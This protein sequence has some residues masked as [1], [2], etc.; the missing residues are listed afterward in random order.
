MS[1]TDEPYPVV[2]PELDAIWTQIQDA[3]RRD[4][5]S[6]LYVRALRGP[7]RKEE[8]EP[9]EDALWRQ[10]EVSRAWREWLGKTSGWRVIRAGLIVWWWDRGGDQEKVPT[11]EE[12]QQAVREVFRGPV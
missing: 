4:D 3:L 2:P 11:L 10:A 12:V 7:Y 6:E 1:F 5:T 9:F 8:G